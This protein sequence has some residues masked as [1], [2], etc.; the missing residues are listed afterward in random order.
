[1]ANQMFQRPKCDAQFFKDPRSIPYG[2]RMLVPE[3]I[4]DNNARFWFIPKTLPLNQLAEGACV[5]YGWS[6]ELAVHPIEIPVWAEFARGLYFG[7]VS[8]DKQEGRFFEEGATVIAGAK[9]AKKAGHIS[10][11]HACFG[12]KEMT[13]ALRVKGPVVI[14][15]PW[16]EGMYQTE[17][18]GLIR[19]SGSLAGGHCLLVVGYIPK[20]ILLKRGFLSKTDQQAQEIVK[21]FGTSVYVLLNSWGPT[22]G[23]SGIG[24]MREPD[25]E[26]LLIQEEGEAYIAT[27]IRPAPKPPY[28]WQRL[29]REMRLS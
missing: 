2:V 13:D 12:M 10:G 5:G 3:Q 9:A 15:I 24:Y 19:V 16:Y 18:S 23:K 21:A 25:M 4:E 8:I 27:D 20:S 11:Y 22:F 14:G 1:V 28:W 17:P 6:G 26:R 29:L 7:A